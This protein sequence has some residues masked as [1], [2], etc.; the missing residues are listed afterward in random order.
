MATGSVDLTDGT[1]LEADLFI[2]AIGVLPNNSFIPPE[3]L[4]PKGW[5]VCDDN[6]A[7]VGMSSV[8]AIGGESSFQI[9]PSVYGVFHPHQNECTMLVVKL[10]PRETMPF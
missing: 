2:S 7:V 9:G 5:V 1:S 4:S 8:Y 10:H 3:F 6:M